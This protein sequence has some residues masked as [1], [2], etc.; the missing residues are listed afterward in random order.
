[1][2]SVS[3]AS[4]GQRT[5]IRMPTGRPPGC[6]GASPTTTGTYRPP[7]GV[8]GCFS[9]CYG[10]PNRPESEV[11]ECLTGGLQTNLQGVWV[12]LLLLQGPTGW[13]LGVWVLFPLKQGPYRL[14]SRVL[15]SCFSSRKEWEMIGSSCSFLNKCDYLFHCSDSTQGAPG[16]LLVVLSQLG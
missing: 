1:M 15:L 5:V 12:L 9:H 11:C 10:G 8:C 4:R 3:K 16:P 13:P 2:S 7:S 14:A 6:G